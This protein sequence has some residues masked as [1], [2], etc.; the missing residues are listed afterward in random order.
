MGTKTQGEA[1]RARVIEA[2]RTLIN[3]KG[4]RN[5][6]IKEVIAATGVQKGNLYFH[7]SSKEDLALTILEEC[8]EEFFEFMAGSLRGRDPLEKLSNF[9]EAILD[10]HRSAGF[11]GGCIV[12]NIALEMSEHNERFAEI[13]R[14]IFHRWTEAIFGLLAEAGASGVLKSPI[15]PRVLAR[16]IVAT[17]EGGIMMSRVSKEETELR[18]CVASLRALLGIKRAVST[19]RKTN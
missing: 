9:F 8:E 15:P 4:F 14:R 2:A 5:T 17:L 16:T 6:T 10:K 3:Q 1:T 7:F 13:I 12:G 19:T 18:S 11:V